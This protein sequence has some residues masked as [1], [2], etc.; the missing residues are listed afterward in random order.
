MP[1]HPPIAL[2]SLDRSHCQCSSFAK[3]KIICLVL[4]ALVALE[5]IDED[6]DRSRSGE[7]VPSNPDN[8]IDDWKDKTHWHSFFSIHTEECVS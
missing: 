5:Q 7:R 4:I 3:Q 2:I 1:R 8:D 6:E